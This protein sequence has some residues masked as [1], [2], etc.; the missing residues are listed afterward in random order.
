ML[1]NADINPQTEIS[2]S[3]TYDFRNLKGKLFM[4]PTSGNSNN[5]NVQKII[6][7][8]DDL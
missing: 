4:P 5:K 7:D 8:D 2:N 1:K 6:E 3:Q